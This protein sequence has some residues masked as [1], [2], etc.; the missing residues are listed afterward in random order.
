[1]MRLLVNGREAR[2]PGAYILGTLLMVL[3]LAFLFFVVRPL[4]GIVVVIAAAAGT[5]YLGARAL[6]LFG[7]K[8]RAKLGTEEVTYRVESSRQHRRD[9]LE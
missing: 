6:G 8:R 7:R 3:V 2:G 9:E 5:V 4:V 1:M